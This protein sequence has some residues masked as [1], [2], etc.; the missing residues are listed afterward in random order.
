MTSRLPDGLSTDAVRGKVLPSIP[1]P[2]R[3]RV[4]QTEIAA[5]ELGCRSVDT[6]GF[7]SPVLIESGHVKIDFHISEMIYGIRIMS[8]LSQAL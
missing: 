6:L 2:A 7:T 5:S 8:S 4:R 1:N 3:L